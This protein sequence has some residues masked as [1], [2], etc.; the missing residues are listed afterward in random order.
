MR[1]VVGVT[2]GVAAYKAAELVRRL[3]QEGLEV[4]VVMTRHAQEF[5]TPLTFA[6]LTGRKVITDMFSAEDSTPA[7]VESAIEHIAVA[8]RADALVIAPATSNTI[9]KLAQGIAD[10]FLSTL[11]L[12]TTA[13]TII[14][15][16]M[17]VNMWEHEATQSNLKTLRARGVHIVAPDEGYLAC[18]MIGAG[19]LAGVDA[20]AHA[21]L[22]VLGIS[23]DL[24]GETILITA[25]PTCEDIDPV[26]YLTN[27]SSGKMGY[28]L[29]DAAHRR[30]A[31][32]IL[33]SGP[34]SIVPPSGVEFVSVRTAEE[35]HRAVRESI[36][37]S[38]VAIMAAAV[39]DFRPAVKEPTKIKRGAN[40]FALELQ[41][42][43]D[44]LAEVASQNSAA[45][46][47]RRIVIGFA[48]ETNNLLEHARKKLAEKG[49]DFI[50]ANDVTQPGAGFDVDTNIVT[51]LFRDARENNSPREERLPKMSKFDVA[52]RVLDELVRMR[53]AS[54][55]SAEHTAAPRK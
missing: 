32:V 5:I 51:L 35:M 3:Q 45:N 39:A 6:A 29:A 47:R 18:G 8:Q 50:V 16:A 25:G 55:I 53:S 10:D 11:Y 34:V 1:V 42:T 2:G 33:I 46:G 13:P 49:A 22:G 37:E 12:A 44:I 48:A 40:G 17:N 30:G 20:I 23:R 9:A 26:R 28:A 4:E 15:P 27:R 21:V 38:S 52:T 7:N 14:A 41:P 36:A 31:K 43:Q 24:A 54:E 19:R